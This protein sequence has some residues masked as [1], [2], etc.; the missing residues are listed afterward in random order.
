MG[1]SS[2]LSCYVKAKGF[3]S[4]LLKVGGDGKNENRRMAVP[5]RI[6]KTISKE[7]QPNFKLVNKLSK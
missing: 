7:N 5:F 4:G 6:T 1:S 2:S 3:K